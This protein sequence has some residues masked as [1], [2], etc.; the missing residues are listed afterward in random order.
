[1]LGVPLSMTQPD[2]QDDS[3]FGEPSGIG[4]GGG[5]SGGTGTE[6]D[7]FARSPGS[8]PPGSIRREDGDT[9]SVPRP[10]KNPL[11]LVALVVG[12]GLLAA[13]GFMFLRSSR[14]AQHSDVTAKIVTID[15]GEALLF[16]V[17]TAPAGS[18]VRFGGQ[19]KPLQAGRATFALAA[20]SLRVGDNVVLADVVSP[21]GTS[22]PARITLAVFYRIWVDTAALRSDKSSLDVIVTALPGTR[23]T[24]DGEDVKLD[25]EGRATRSYPIDVMTDAKAGMIDHVVHYRVQPP[26]GETVVDAL[27]TQVPVAGL[28]VDRPGRQVVTAHESIDIA[29][30]VGKDSQVTV[31]G[32]VV[33]VKDGRFRYRYPLPAPNTYKPRVVASAAGKA[34]MGVTLEIR[35]VESL[36]SAEAEFGADRDITYAKLAPNPAIYR[37]QKIALEGRVYATDARGGEGV[38]QMFARPCPSSQ[39]CSVWI[40]DPTETEVKVDDWIRVLGIVEGEQQFRSEKND[41]VTVPKIKA[42]FI[43]PAKP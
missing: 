13:A 31:D 34:P 37:G 36:A 3:S 38:I 29:G 32:V 8:E 19:E 9:L 20:D 33:P 25:A 43:L 30:E 4:N 23:I 2:Q 7:S 26:S 10:R 14:G 21:D 1:M 40:S 18:K 6:L 35:R 41:V 12:L 42:S 28:Q 16:E 11:V 17:P 22:E 24:L 5:S 39:R 27:H 15:T